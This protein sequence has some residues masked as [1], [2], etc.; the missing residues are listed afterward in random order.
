MTVKRA[1]EAARQWIIEEASGIPGFRGAYTAGSTNWLTD[2][3]DLSTAS[4]LDIMVVLADQ[5]EAGRRGKFIY[6]DTLLEVSY[7][8]SDQL[9]SPDQF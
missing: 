3:A 8:R 7:L 5:N 2:D 1:R 4:D 9:Q 6:Q